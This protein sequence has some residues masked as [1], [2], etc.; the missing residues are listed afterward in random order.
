MSFSIFIS[1][2]KLRIS[3]SGIFYLMS[4]NL[5]GQ[6]VHS[7]IFNKDDSKY[8]TFLRLTPMLN[9]MAIKIANCVSI[10]YQER[11]GLGS[12]DKENQINSRKTLLLSN[13]KVDYWKWAELINYVRMWF[14]PLQD[15]TATLSTYLTI[16]QIQYICQVNGRK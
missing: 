2:Q 6:N 4:R 12:R 3:I 1:K 16:F 8:H 13:L 10:Q 7:L 15:F 14:H 11:Q 9:M 5:Q